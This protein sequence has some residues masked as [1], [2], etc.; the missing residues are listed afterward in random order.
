MMFR[1]LDRC[2]TTTWCSE[3]TSITITSVSAVRLTAFI[4]GGGVYCHWVWLPAHFQFRLFLC[5]CVCHEL[6]FRH[7]WQC[8]IVTSREPDVP[9]GTDCSTRSHAMI[10]SSHL[11]THY[12]IMHAYSLLTQLL[13]VS[14][15]LSRHLHVA[16]T[17]ISFKYT[18][19]KIGHNNHTSALLIPQ[20]CTFILTSLIPLSQRKFC[21]SCLKIAR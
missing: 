15:L 9:C 10:N 4:A 2:Q 19:I 5:V 3:S 7:W 18:S 6:C 1:I 8:L 20:I 11:Q 17:N 13:H 14:A 12:S 21:V 16:D